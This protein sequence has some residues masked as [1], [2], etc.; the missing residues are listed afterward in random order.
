MIYLQY[1]L[2]VFGFTVYLILIIKLLEHFGR[3]DMALYFVSPIFLYCLG[4]ALRLSGEKSFI[5]I[6]YFFTDSTSLIIYTIFSAM[7]VLGQL[8]Y[9]KK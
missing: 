7:L 2:I 5:D 1:F 3:K 8:K 4:F 6:G 9:W